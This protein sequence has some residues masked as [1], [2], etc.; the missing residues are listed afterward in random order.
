MP[1][2]P[3]PCYMYNRYLQESEREEDVNVEIMQHYIPTS[4]T[5]ATC[6]CVHYVQE[7]EGE[8][9]GNMSSKYMYIPPIFDPCY[10]YIMCRNHRGKRVGM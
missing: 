3:D 10:M 9:G 7:S 1:A 5:H 4:L 6:T 8:E 2:F